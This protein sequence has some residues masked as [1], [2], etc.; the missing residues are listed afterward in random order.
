M[1]PFL[2]RCP[3]TSFLVQ[4]FSAEIEGSDDRRRRYEAIDCLAC[5]S[6]HLVNPATGKLMSEEA[7]DRE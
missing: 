5:G 7:G 2:F 6:M 3:L 4:G 1:P